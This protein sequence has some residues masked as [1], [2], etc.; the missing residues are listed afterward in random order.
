MCL[1]IS[2]P[3]CYLSLKLT[4]FPPQDIVL[5]CY[6]TDSPESL[7]NVQEMWV[8]EIK[9]YCPKTPI[10]LIAT[11]SDLKNEK[12]A[13]RYVCVCVCRWQLVSSHW[14]RAS[15]DTL[16]REFLCL[17][18]PLIS[19]L[20]LAASTKARKWALWFKHAKWSSARPCWMSMCLTFSTALPQLHLKSDQRARRAVRVLYYKN[21]Q[22][23]TTAT[24]THNHSS[25]ERF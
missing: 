5:I 6:S 3:L 20:N 13:I 12:S 19:T 25:S 9:H 8:D 14:L 10:L 23:S 17:F 16:S 18:Q 21:D 22:F 15:I 1:L 2:L 4:F 11:K 7:R 24:H